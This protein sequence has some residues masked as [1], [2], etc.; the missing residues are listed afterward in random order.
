[1]AVNVQRGFIALLLFCLGAASEFGRRHSI[2]FQLG[3]RIGA[4]PRDVL[5]ASSLPK[6]I[7]RIL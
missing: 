6:Q 4:A 5:R 1:V 7:E 3:L 2:V